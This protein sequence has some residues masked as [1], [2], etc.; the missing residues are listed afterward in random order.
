MTKTEPELTDEDWLVQQLEAWPTRVD[1]EKTTNIEFLM[2]E[3]AKRLRST[4]APDALREAI[5]T[6]I[7]HLEQG[8][9]NQGAMVALDVLRTALR[10]EGKP[11]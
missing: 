7:R 11:S 6:A 4:P 9:Q 5:E 8:K 1:P 10:T 2:K 3:A